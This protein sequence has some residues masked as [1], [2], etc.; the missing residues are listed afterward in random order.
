MLAGPSGPLSAALVRLA[1]GPYIVSVPCAGRLALMSMQ[2]GSTLAG[3]FDPKS[4]ITLHFGRL[5]QYPQLMHS[6]SVVRWVEWPPL[7]PIACMGHAVCMQG[8]ARTVGANG[9]MKKNWGE[10]H[11]SGGA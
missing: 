3:I 11:T 5:G 7:H 2:Q 6:A 9:F 10:M 8:I 4:P 1:C